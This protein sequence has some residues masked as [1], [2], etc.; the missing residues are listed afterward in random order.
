MYALDAPH[1]ARSMRS[2]GVAPVK[3]HPSAQRAFA[4][5]APLGLVH[6]MA[7]AQVKLLGPC[8]KTGRKGHRPTRD[9]DAARDR[10]SLAIRDH[11]NTRPLQSQER[12]ACQPRP[13]N[14]THALGPKRTVRRVRRQRSAGADRA[15]KRAGSLRIPNPQAAPPS[16]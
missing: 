6:P 4:F 8:F 16:P 2:S 11:S 5:T 3:D 10:I 9:R 15:D 1:E 12:G 13:T 7:R 14:F